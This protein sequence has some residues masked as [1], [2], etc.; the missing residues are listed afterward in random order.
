MSLIRVRSKWPFTN[1]FHVL[2]IREEGIEYEKRIGNIPLKT[3]SV[4]YPELDNVLLQTTIVD[5]IL[6]FRTTTLIIETKDTDLKVIKFPGVER[7]TATTLLP[8]LTE[9]SG[10]SRMKLT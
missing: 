3:L 5:L 4:S 9:K 6:M 2:T 7:G 8:F 10:R 1:F